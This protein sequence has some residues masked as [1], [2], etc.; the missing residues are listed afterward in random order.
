MKRKSSSIWNYFDEVNADT[1]K[2]K[3]CL[4]VYSRKGKTTTSLKSHLKCMHVAEYDQFNQ[5]EVE[6][7]NKQ[8]STSTA[9]LQEANKQITLKETLLQNEKWC[10]T[11]PKSMEIDRLISEMIC[12]QDLPINFVEGIGFR[13]LMEFVSPNYQLSGRKFFTDYVSAESDAQDDVWSFFER[14]GGEARCA[15]CRALVPIPA[16]RS[17][18]RNN[19][20]KLVDVV[21]SEEETA[22]N[23]AQEDVYTEVVY[24][25]HEDSPKRAPK[26]IEKPTKPKQFTERRTKKRKLS[27][28]SDD[29]PLKYKKKRND[30]EIEQFGKYITCLLKKIPQDTS[31]ELQMEI[32]NLIM[33]K[34]LEQRRNETSVL[35]ARESKMAGVETVDGGCQT[36]FEIKISDE[37]SLSNGYSYSIEKIVNDETQMIQST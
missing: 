11:N 29:E 25:E 3:L 20:P 26:P 23:N 28:S 15:V 8:P 7:I 34:Q 19:H 30:D 21:E 4:K 32:V 33:K 27:S 24:L 5:S 14:A 13:R 37:K 18:L 12:L 31:M 35:A 36:A 2:C 1:A 16:L 22:T 6:K 10:N 17:H 9:T